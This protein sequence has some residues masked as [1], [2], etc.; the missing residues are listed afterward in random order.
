MLY[1]LVVVSVVVVGANDERMREFGGVVWVRSVTDECLRM[2]EGG[3][4][5]YDVGEGTSDSREGEVEGERGERAGDVV[6]VEKGF[7]CESAGADRAHPGQ[8]SHALRPGHRCCPP[9]HRSS[10]THPT[11]DFLCY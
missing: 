11:L 2:R 8:R 6:G 10:C 5:V 3:E 4:G 1:N 7:R 9:H